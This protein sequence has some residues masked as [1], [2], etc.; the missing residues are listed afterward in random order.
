MQVR[1]VAAPDDIGHA[2][3]VFL[4]SFGEELDGDTRAAIVRSLR[5]HPCVAAF[6]GQ[7]MVGSAAALRLELTLPGEVVASAAGVTLVGV[8][9]T[10]RRRGVLTA[11]LERVLDDARGAGYALAALHASESAIYGRF[12]FGPAT[13]A[14]D[15]R[16]D[17][18]HAGFAGP[19]EDGGRID[20]AEPGEALVALPDLFERHRRG[21]PGEVSRHPAWWDVVACDP[22]AWRDGAGPLEYALHRDVHGTADG[23]ALYRRAPRFEAAIPA[24]TLRVEEVVAPDP[25]VY[26]A[27]WRYLLDV[28]LVAAVTART[29]APQ[30]PLRWLLADP[31][32]LVATSY[33]DGLWL[34]PLDL[35][36]CLTARRYTADGTLVLEVADRQIPA[37]AGRWLLQVANG[38]AACEPATVAPDLRLDVAEVGSLLLGGVDAAALAAAGRISGDG[39]AVRRAGRLLAWDRAPH[40]RTD[41]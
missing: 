41:F 25:A 2:V 37:N 28:D 36:R 19:V 10:H 9:P 20:L 23:Y 6:D 39:E 1:S 29:L 38:V 12:G 22:E 34:R 33:R 30:E 7:R 32:R 8:L 26:A 35:P 14:L 13:W 21:C 3:D 16:I 31:R 24:G 15:A 5:P 27:L 4:R 11:M 17:T 18:V 40:C